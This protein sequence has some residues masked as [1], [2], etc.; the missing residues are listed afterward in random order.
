MPRSSLPAGDAELYMCGSN[1][2]CQLGHKGPPEVQATPRRLEALDTVGVSN[3]ACWPSHVLA[4][5]REGAIASWG[6]ADLE[7]TG[8]GLPAL[9]GHALLQGAIT[10]SAPASLRFVNLEQTGEYTASA[11]GR[12]MPGCSTADR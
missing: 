5:I 4:V 6:A 8:G 3:L 2:S 11:G 1:E 10:C 7:Q 9:L 12:E